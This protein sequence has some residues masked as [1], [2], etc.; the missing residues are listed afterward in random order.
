MKSYDQSDGQGALIFRHTKK[1]LSVLEITTIRPVDLQSNF[2][3]KKLIK[4]MWSS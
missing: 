3:K 2:T 4:R 1:T